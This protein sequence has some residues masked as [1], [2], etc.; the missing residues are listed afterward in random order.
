MRLG[1]VCSRG[2]CRRKA[3]MTLTYI[4]ADS[5]AVVGPL[6]TF[7]EPHAYD[8]CEFHAERLTVPNGWSVIRQ[9]IDSSE[10]GP[11]TDDLMAI[12]DAV[13]EVANTSSGDVER[14]QG[15]ELGRRGHLRA[16]P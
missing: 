8:L 9:E 4:Y 7:A 10:S 15:P 11:S 12:A 2:G 5:V 14:S 1:R 13:R 6:A 16:V 3:V